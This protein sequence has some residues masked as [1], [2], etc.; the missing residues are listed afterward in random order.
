MPWENPPSPPFRKGGILFTD[1]LLGSCAPSLLKVFLQG[2]S[3]VAQVFEADLSEV[4]VVQNGIR[5]AVGP[6]T[7]GGAGRC[8]Q[9]GSQAGHLKDRRSKLV[10]HNRY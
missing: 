9:A 7:E 8:P 1:K 6:G 10:R 3:P 5:G 4:G 2:V